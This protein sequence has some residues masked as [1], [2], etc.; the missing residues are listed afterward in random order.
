[1][2]PDLY[3]QAPVLTARDAILVRDFYEDRPTAETAQALGVSRQRVSQLY[4]A[5]RARG[6]PLESQ[7]RSWAR[8]R[9]A[10]G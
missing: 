4:A 9:Q 6:V 8:G 3:A 2:R 7:A 1:M 5:L 10:H